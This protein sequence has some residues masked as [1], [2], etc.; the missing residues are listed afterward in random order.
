[1][2]IGGQERVICLDVIGMRSFLKKA[3][4]GCHGL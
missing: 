1:M 2:S 3:S 4:Q